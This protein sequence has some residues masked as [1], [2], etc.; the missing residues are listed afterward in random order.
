MYLNAVFV[1]IKVDDMTLTLFYCD[2]KGHSIRGHGGLAHREFTWVE[3]C[4]YIENCPWSV[5]GAS[6]G[7][8]GRKGLTRDQIWEQECVC[9]SVLSKINNRRIGQIIA[10]DY[11]SL[12]QPRV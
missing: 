10:N 2:V 6:W 9:R 4:S 11:I 3:G 7:H 5:I 12:K 1:S 8:L